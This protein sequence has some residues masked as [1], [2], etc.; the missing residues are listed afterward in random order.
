M[1][2]ALD[3]TN[4]ITF[5]FSFMKMLRVDIL[6]KFEIPGIGVT[7]WD[8][9]IGLAITAIVLT[10]LVNTVRIGTVNYSSKGK[11][12]RPSPS[13]ILTQKT[14]T[15]KMNDGFGGTYTDTYSKSSGGLWVKR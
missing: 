11:G 2:V 14:T 4:A 1:T 10:V 9:L 6:D 3:N 8:F 13:P 7:Y 15:Q 12:D 5:F